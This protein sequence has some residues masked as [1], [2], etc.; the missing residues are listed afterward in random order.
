MQKSGPLAK[1]GNRDR[2]PACNN[3]DMDELD[4]ITL[5]RARSGD[6]AALSALMR[7]YGGSVHALSCRMLAGC[8]HAV[9]EDLCQEALVKVIQGI[10]R[11]DPGGPARL[12]TWV[13]TVATR[14]L[15]DHLRRERR[16]PESELPQE[17]PSSRH[18]SP[19]QVATGREL[20][21]Q[22]ERAMAA[23]PDEQRAVLV[24]R[25]Y[26]DLDY[27]EIATMLGL[28]LGT[29]KSRLGRAR[30]ALRQVLARRQGAA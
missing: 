20:A 18:A 6:A 1:S 4:A 27:E 14:T 12:S 5:G 23:L 26:H 10:H 21:R 22:V 28:E 2:R 29:V 30:L 9:V 13:L 15:I 3:A 24:L 16:H 8:P 25:A 7:T 11:F 17:E 19:E